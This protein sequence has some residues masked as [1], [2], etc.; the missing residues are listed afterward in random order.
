MTKIFTKRTKAPT[1]DN[2]WY[3]KDNV[4]YKTKWSMFKKHDGKYGNCTHYSI[5]RYQEVNGKKCKLQEENADT[6]IEQAKK[7]GYKTGMTPKLGAIIVWKHTTKKNGHVGNVERIYSNSDL[8]ISMSGYATYLFKI[9]KVTKKS[10]YVYSDYKL[11]GFIYPDDEYTD[12]EEIFLPKLGTYTL[13]DVRNVYTSYPN[14]SVRKLVK[15]L[16]RDGQKHATSKKLTDKATLEK[17]TK[18][19]VSKVVKNDE[20]HIW[21]KIPS[22][23]ICLI[24]NDGTKHYK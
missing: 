2:R 8:D 21:G 19:S 20:G 4:S 5:G 6:F 11:L 16:T 22:G 10:G 15:D 24:S 3:G 14:K 1:E 9:R 12:K 18:V 13:T 7:Y 17:G 23:W